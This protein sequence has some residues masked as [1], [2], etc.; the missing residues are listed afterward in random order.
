VYKI[1][2][3]YL[4][5]SILLCYRFLKKSYEPHNIISMADMALEESC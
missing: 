5:S 3:E 2:I 1:E 4:S